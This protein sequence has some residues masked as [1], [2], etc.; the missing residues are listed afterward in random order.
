MKDTDFP[1]TKRLKKNPRFK[2]SFSWQQTNNKRN[3]A[4]K[5]KNLP[6]LVEPLFF[7]GSFQLEVSMIFLL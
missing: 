7:Q 6:P 1:D 5:E 3:Q 4:Y 2:I